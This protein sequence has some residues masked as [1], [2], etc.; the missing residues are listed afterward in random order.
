MLRQVMDRIKKVTND[1]LI[2]NQKTWELLKTFYDE[3][4][5]NYVVEIK[6]EINEKKTF[7]SFNDAYSTI[8][9]HKHNIWEICIKGNNADNHNAEILLHSNLSRNY[10]RPS[11]QV[12]I[13]FSETDNNIIEDF[14]DELFLMTINKYEVHKKSFRYEPGLT[15]LYGLAIGIYTASVLKTNISNTFVI[16]LICTAILAVLYLLRRK[17]EEVLKLSPLDMPNIVFILD[18]KNERAYKNRNRK[19]HLYGVPA[20]IIGFALSLLAFWFFHN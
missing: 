17:I 12:N 14:V 20:T 19:R 11:I 1:T 9:S 6:A 4:Y 13:E 10:S 2:F 3:H 5:S 15:Y 18:E 8:D 16:V 7:N